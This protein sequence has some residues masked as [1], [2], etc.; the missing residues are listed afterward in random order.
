[1]SRQ[2]ARGHNERLERHELRKV[3]VPFSGEDD[4]GNAVSL[5]GF[6]TGTVSTYLQ[7]QRLPALIACPI[8]GKKGGI[9]RLC[10]G[11]RAYLTEYTFTDG[12]RLRLALLPTRVP[13]KTG[14]RRLKWIAYVVI[15]LDWSAAKCYQR[16]R[17]RFGIES[18]YRQLGL[19]PPCASCSSTVGF[20][21]A[22]PP[23]VCWSGVLHAG[24]FACFTFRVLLPFYV[25]RLNVPLA[26]AMKPLSMPSRPIFDLL[27]L[28]CAMKAKGL[29]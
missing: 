22:L 26:P 17:R 5:P 11:K 4:G 1:M 25:V 19:I 27:K 12:T 16:Y 15:H 2:V 24:S 29:R 18:S 23:P 9:R 20:T 21:C 7:Q 3:H 6:C 28:N 10:H 13:D 8:R 14:K